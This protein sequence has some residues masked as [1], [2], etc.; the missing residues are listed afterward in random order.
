MSSIQ[1][2]ETQMVSVL[3]RCLSV[4]E[5]LSVELTFEDSIDFLN[6]AMRLDF[7]GEDINLFIEEFV[8]MKQHKG[9]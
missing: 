1:M 2:N 3:E 5:E 7:H 8:S 9:E 6:T 4:A